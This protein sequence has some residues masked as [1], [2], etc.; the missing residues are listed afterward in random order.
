MK[1][2]ITFSDEMQ[3]YT[4]TP[5]TYIDL[6]MDE[7][8][9]W[10]YI[11]Q[12]LYSELKIEPQ[13]IYNGVTVEFMAE[14]P[15]KQKTFGLTTCKHCGEMFQKYSRNEKYCCFQ[16]A[17]CGRKNGLK[18]RQ[19]KYLANEQN[20]T[21]HLIRLK[22][23]YRMRAEQPTV[24]EQCGTRGRLHFHHIQYA[25]EYIT[26]GH[27]LCPKCHSQQHKGKIHDQL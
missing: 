15:I 18:A 5:Y 2:L 10:D 17:E 1:Y 24:C 25:D 4:N 20:R 6:A 7:Q 13:I 9:A 12:Q 21:K 27:W 14:H 3:K 8:D 11:R 22:T 26:V 19:N 16:C 23:H